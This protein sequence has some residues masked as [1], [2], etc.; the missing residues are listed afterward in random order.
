MQAAAVAAAS[1][2]MPSLTAEQLNSLVHSDAFDR[3]FRPNASYNAP[4]PEAMQ[5]FVLGRTDELMPTNLGDT[6]WG[7]AHAH[8]HIHRPG[9]L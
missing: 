5:A 8:G 1:M 4:S 3:Q 7:G 6:G 2:S 9:Q